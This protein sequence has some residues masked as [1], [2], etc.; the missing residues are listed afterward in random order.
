MQKRNVQKLSSKVLTRG[1]KRDII[2]E[3]SPGKREGSE[4]S[5]GSR[6]S[7]R[8]SCERIEKRVEKSQKNFQK[9]LDKRK[10][11]CYNSQAVTPEGDGSETVFEN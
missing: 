8:I 7:N 1:K 2:G 11:A 4:R 5:K 6:D 9:P 3:L 10:A